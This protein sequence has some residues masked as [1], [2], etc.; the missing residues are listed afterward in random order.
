MEF[1]NKSRILLSTLAVYALL[2]FIGYSTPYIFALLIIVG[3]VLYFRGF[4]NCLS[5]YEYPIFDKNLIILFLIWQ[6]IIIVRGVLFNFPSFMHLANTAVLNPYSVLAMLIPII[7]FVYI[8][9]F[10]F[11]FCLKI[12]NVVGFFA[13]ILVLVN[14]N[15]L[16]N[17]DYSTFSS[18]EE[19]SY[20]TLYNLQSPIVNLLELTAFGFFLPAF[21]S[22]KKWLLFVLFAM[23]ALYIS[24]FAARRGASVLWILLSTAGFYLYFKSKNENRIINYLFMIIVIITLLSFVSNNLGTT[25]SLLGERIETDNRNA[26]EIAFWEDMLNGYDFVWGRGLNGT[27][28]CPMY[29]NGNWVVNRNAIETGY[30]YLVLEG[31]IIN[32]ILYTIIMLRSAYFGWFMSN[33]NFSKACSIF[34]AIYLFYLIPFGLPAFSLTYL[35]VW[36]GVRACLSDFRYYSDDD[37]YNLLFF[38]SL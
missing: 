23:I 14:Y 37:V 1:T 22:K 26:I 10:D 5:T 12:I 30:C 9:S 18:D 33:N 24:L 32:L 31:G 2:P 17:V 6:I 21:I 4:K 7:S 19:T 3:L 27:Y 15:M 28:F 13:L 36:I 25:F 29:E 38:K 16:F 11:H 34:I 35:F 8:E 20:A